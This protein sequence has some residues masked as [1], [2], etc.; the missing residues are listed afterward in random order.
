MSF[1][2]T[3]AITKTLAAGA[4]GALGACGG[5]VDGPASKAPDPAATQEEKSDAV[6]NIDVN[7]ERLRALE[8]VGVG[9][10]IVKLPAEAT[11]CYGPCPGY[12]D[13]PVKAKEDAAARLEAL[14]DVAEG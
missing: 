12:E 3:N 5:S 10:L 13:A 14:A 8:V 2:M 6:A 9:D 7:L 4:L 1:K 11:N